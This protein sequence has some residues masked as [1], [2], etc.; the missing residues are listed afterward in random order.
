M[1]WLTDAGAAGSRYQVIRKLGSGAFGEVL[2]GRDLSCGALVALKKVFI[3]DI[4][5]GIPESIAREMQGLRA[6]DHPNVIRLLDVYPR[7]SGRRR[8]C[9]RQAQ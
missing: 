3:K 2:L 6:A 9:W 7:V 4:S 8:R 1:S 5:D